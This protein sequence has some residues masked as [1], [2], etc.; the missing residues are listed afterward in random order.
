MGNRRKNGKRPRPGPNHGDRSPIEPPR[1]ALRWALLGVVVIAAT[2]AATY[3]NSLHNPFLFDDDRCIV[4]N[5]AITQLFPVT[6]ILT[7]RPQSR[8]IIN[9]TLA[10][11]YAVSELDVW[12]YHLFNLAVHILAGIALFGL[13]RRTLALE[14]LRAWVG[15]AGTALALAVALIW[16]V[17]PLQTSAVSYTIQRAESVMGLF[18]LLTMYCAVRAFTARARWRWAWYAAAVVACAL[19]MGSKQVMLTA[20]IM[21][22]IYEAV[23]VTGSLRGALRR[24]WLLYAGLAASWLLLFPSFSLL[25]D[26]PTA[27]FG[28]DKVTAWQYARTQ[29]GVIVHYLRLSFLP[30]GL[31]LDY[32]WPVAE[33]VWQVLPPALLIAGLLALTLWSLRRRPRAGFLGV[34]FFGILSVSSTIIPIADLAFEHR[35]YLS[36]AA[37]VC[38]VV[39][40]GYVLIQQVLTRLIRAERPRRV[41]LAASGSLLAAGLVVLLALGTVA[42]NA[43]YETKG[44]MWSDVVAKRP[45][46]A[47]A[48]YN[49]GNHYAREGQN[50]QAVASYLKA[51][52]I[53]PDYGH[54]QYN[55]GNVLR[56]EKRYDEAIRYYKLAIEH[57]ET[58]GS[59]KKLAK[60][61]NN[62][63]STLVHQNKLDEA[64]PY[65]KRAA[66]I[67]PDY[68]QAYNNLGVIHMRR[69]ELDEAIEYYQK[70][71]R[72][73][74][75]YTDARSNLANALRRNGQYDAAIAQYRLALQQKRPDDWQ[76]SFAEV[77]SNIGGTLAAQGKHKEA[78]KYFRKAAELAPNYAEAHYNLAVVL[79]KQGRREEAVRAYQRALRIRPDYAMAHQNLG[80][81]LAGARQ[82]APAIHHFKAA[83]KCKP[84]FI[85][86][87]NNLAWL[88]ATCPDPHLRDGRQ[89]L[90]LAKQVCRTTG[91]ESPNYMDALSA[92]YA[93][94]GQFDKALDA[95]QRALQLASASGK[96]NLARKFQQRVQLY[97]SGKP[98]RF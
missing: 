69:G 84:R 91:Y 7:A 37:V 95:A 88:L 47:R 13:V 11:N 14:R 64:I 28:M 32:R 15:R 72:L 29:F 34:W 16:L 76:K 41:L 45:D 83:I 6:D 54:A 46:N 48:R 4:R 24:D 68:A 20:P 1:L 2:G 75:D 67:K 52:E 65:Y 89:A 70:A 58:L 85:A 63:A 43:M 71:V 92:A 19:G 44:K 9:L 62:L 78:E 3:H 57:R 21:V 50:D 18:Y 33:S 97:E 77:H 40:G 55:L 22:L 25:V 8:P 93:E 94:T 98:L 36:L 38:L 82:Y 80:L 10:V 56:K 23:F 73:E 53:Q 96:K 60:V 90:K 35:M 74:A 81:L 86:A 61:Y 87:M 31:C 51:I 26:D 12:S 27:G 30:V 5:T 42:R 49:L 79:T 59:R 66:Q 17:H 39:V